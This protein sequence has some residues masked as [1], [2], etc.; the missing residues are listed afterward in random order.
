MRTSLVKSGMVKIR[1]RRQRTSP[2]VVYG[3]SLKSLKLFSISTAKQREHFSVSILFP[4]YTPHASRFPG[5]C[6][7]KSRSGKKTACGKEVSRLN[8]KGRKQN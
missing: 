8:L 5:A 7:R 2:A 6:Y 1:K 4:S 3:G